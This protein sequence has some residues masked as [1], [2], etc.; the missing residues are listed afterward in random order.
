VTLNHEDAAHGRAQRLSGRFGRWPP[1]SAPRDPSIG[2][3]GAD[4][5]ARARVDRIETRFDTPGR[6]RTGDIHRKVRDGLGLT[7]RVTDRHGRSR[8][9]T[10][11]FRLQLQD[12][13]P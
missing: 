11:A 12:P 13:D 4:R 2:R 7:I 5:T 6:H 9:T 8:R 1:L 10:S 3:P